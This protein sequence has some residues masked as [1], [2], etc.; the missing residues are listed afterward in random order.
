MLQIFERCWPELLDELLFRQADRAEVAH[1]CEES[2]ANEVHYLTGI[3]PRDP[4]DP[5][6]TLPQ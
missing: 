3:D 2:A 4:R 6:G 5:S 1:L